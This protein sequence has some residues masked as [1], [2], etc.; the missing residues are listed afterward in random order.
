M[1]I[2][3]FSQKITLTYDGDTKFR[4][5]L[6]AFITMLLL[7]CVIAYSVFR[8]NDLVNRKNAAISKSSFMRDLN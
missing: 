6:G 3:L 4:T 7:L 5:K 1:L 8:T 2:D